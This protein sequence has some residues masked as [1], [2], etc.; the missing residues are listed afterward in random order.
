MDA[1]DFDLARRIVG[2]PGAAVTACT[3][4]GSAASVVAAADAATYA[5][6]YA[7][8]CEAT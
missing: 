6:A 4:A 7:Y 3:E 1:L 2:A 8:A 5:C